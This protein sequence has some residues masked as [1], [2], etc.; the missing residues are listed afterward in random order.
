MLVAKM[1]DDR[2]QA[3][4]DV[5]QRGVNADHDINGLVSDESK[6]LGSDFLIGPLVT[7]MVVD[8]TIADLGEFASKYIETTFFAGSQ[9]CRLAHPLQ[10]IRVLAEYLDALRCRFDVLERDEKA[11]DPVIHE[12]S[13]R[14]PLVSERR[15]AGGHAFEHG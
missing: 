14:S 13:W 7:A 8:D 5:L 12:F 6:A 3:G 9:P 2:F 15:S 10:S 1:A 11:R 4:L